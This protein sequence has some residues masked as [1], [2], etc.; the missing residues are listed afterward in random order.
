MEQTVYIDLYFLVNM[1]MDLLCLL[2]TAALLHRRVKRWRVLLSAVLGGAY[3]AFSLL[4]GLG[5]ALGFLGDALIAGAMCALTFGVKT[6]T[7]WGFLRPAGML[8][9]S[10]ALLG[11]IMTALYAA[12]NRLHLPL[13]ALSGD[14]LSVWTF[15]ILG[16]TA[17]FFTLRGGK[18]FGLSR[19]TKT[20]TVEAVVLGHALKFIALVDSGNHLRDPV[21]GKSV[22]AAELSLF[23]DILPPELLEACRTGAFADAL[24]TGR[25]AKLLRPIPAKTAAGSTVL[26]A[27]VPERLI[28]FDG[29]ERF[30]GDHLLAP[31]PIHTDG[32]F[33]AVIAPD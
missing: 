17:G 23:R 31:A 6:R 13:E 20:V 14:S 15:A 16:A 4:F 9:L 11:G 21:S 25:Y 30:D 10:S 33:D 1:S 29:R 28:V 5:G 22:I 19:K 26:L 2:I 24:A 32:S 27:I 7:V 8:L 18:L 12:L 3:S